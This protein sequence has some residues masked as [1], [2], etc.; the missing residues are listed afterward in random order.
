MNIVFIG[1][2]NVAW[3]LAQALDK[4]GHKITDIYSRTIANAKKLCSKLYDAQ[5]TNSLDFTASQATLFVIAVPDNAVLEIVEKASFPA[6]S[7]VVHTSGT[8]SMDELEDVNTKNIG[9][10]Y[11]LQTFSKTKQVDFKTIPI[12]IE[13]SDSK[14]EKIIEKVAFSICENVCFYDSEDRK[15]LHLAAVIAC[16]FSNYMLKMSE[17]ILKEHGLDFAILKPLIKET[18]EK[19]LEIGPKNAQTGPAMR[20]D[21]QTIQTQLELLSNKPELKTIYKLISEQIMKQN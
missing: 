19:A 18:I 5:A 4:N 20:K 15:K 12:C 8:L 11:P 13:A 1:S 6:N 7:I 9:V 2:G 3:H 14:T 10:F 21:M 16:N 17:Q